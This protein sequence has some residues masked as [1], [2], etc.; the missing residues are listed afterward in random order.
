M[1]KRAERKEKINLGDDLIHPIEDILT[2]KKD[3][4][5]SI[6]GLAIILFVITIIEMVV[7]LT[8][9]FEFGITQ[10][11][12]FNDISCAVSSCSDIDSL[13]HGRRSVKL[14]Y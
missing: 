6:F 8:G 7:V 3:I 9:F 14:K 5:K 11:R 10:G 13:L 1:F 4:S 2:K 12:S